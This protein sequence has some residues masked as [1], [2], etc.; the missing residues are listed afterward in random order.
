MRHCILVLLAGF[1]PAPAP[2]PLPAQQVAGA[3]LWRLP[4]ATLAVPPALAHHGAG[5]FWNPAQPAS[6]AERASVALE[7][8]QTAPTVGA[9]GVLLTARAR[10]GGVGRVGLV[11]GRVAIGDLVRTSLSPDPDPG[12]IPFYTQTAGATWSLATGPVTLGA[13]LAHQDTKLDLVS[14]HRWT[15]DVGARGAVS[16]ALT[17]AV[18]THFFSRLAVD[19]PAQDVYGGIEVRVWRGSLWGSR[20]VAWGRY[21]IAT[22][23]RFGTDHQ[24]GATLEIGSQ[25]GSEVLVTRESGYGPVGW[26]FVPGIRVGVGHYHVS[27]AR[28]GGVNDVGA[29]YRVGLE[30]T[31][32]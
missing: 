20:A 31:V 21:G 29:A 22:A 28:D 3:E 12:T 32:P 27:F 14:A 18:A 2:A 24:V 7:V 8:I 17:V 5:A 6:A 16:E 4:A 30:A 15:L 23:H 26:R 1:T 25:F 9:A 19:D 13:T 11:Y 10:V